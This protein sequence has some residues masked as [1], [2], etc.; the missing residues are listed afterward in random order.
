MHGVENRC[1]CIACIIGILIEPGTYVT[2]K[3]FI[4]GTI[5]RSQTSSPVAFDDVPLS[6]PHYFHPVFI[7]NG[8]SKSLAEMSASDY[9]DHDYRRIT[10][11]KILQ[12][13]ESIDIKSLRH[14]QLD[15]I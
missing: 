11:D 3:T 14:K 8:E 15:L 2:E 5:S 10:T 4:Y 1:A 6:N 7:P 9:Y 12:K 13:L